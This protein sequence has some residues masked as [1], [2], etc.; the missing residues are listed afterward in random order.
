MPNRILLSLLP[1]LILLIA[2][3]YPNFLMS[4]PPAMPPSPAI[5]IGSGLAGLSVSSQLLTHR[6][7]VIL[8]DRAPKPGGNSIKASSGINGSPTPYQPV[9]EPEDAFFNDTMKSAGPVARPDLISTLTKNSASAVSWLSDKGIDM[10]KVAQLGGHTYARTHRGSGGKPPGFAII[11]TLLSELKAN[12]LFDL[13]SSCTVTRVLKDSARVTGVEYTNADGLTNELHGPIIFAS[14]GYAGDPDGMLKTHRPDLANY[15]STNDA[16]PGM[17]SLLTAIGAQLV[18]MQHVQVHPTGFIDPSDP[19]ARVKF[20]A[21]EVLRG[22]GGI[23]LLNGKR[24]VN[25]LDTR[26]HVAGAITST[27]PTVEENRVKQW[28]IQIVLDEGAYAAAKSHVDFY[29][30]KGLMTKCTISSLLPDALE[31]IASYAA[32]ASGASPEPFGRKA[33]ANWT[34]TN[35]SS[36]SIVYVGTVTPVIHFTMGGVLINEDAEV[37]DEQGKAIEGLWAAGEVTGGVHGGNRLGGS[38]LLECVVFGRRA[39]EGVAKFLAKE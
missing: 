8:L 31:S 17:H 19:G 13:R 26:E 15:P 5:V 10:S 28:P 3:L 35:P 25:E 38:S 11:S 14:G 29:I 1:F 4:T 20:L 9:S 36:D 30:F 16:R 24:F 23:L 39:G 6:I 2:Y 34:L 7:P 12:E 27:Q 37:L 22:E 21:A 18:D 33:F 32:A